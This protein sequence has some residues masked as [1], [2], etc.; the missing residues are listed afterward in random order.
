[1]CFGIGAIIQTK[2]TRAISQNL[3]HAQCD[4]TSPRSVCA[5]DPPELELGRLAIPRISQ[6][7]RR[8]QKHPAAHV[9]DN[10]EKKTGMD[11]SITD[12][13]TFR[14]ETK[15]SRQAMNG[16]LGTWSRINHAESHGL[17]AVPEKLFRSNMSKSLCREKGVFTITGRALLYILQH[18]Y[19]CDGI[20]KIGYYVENTSS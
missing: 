19:K 4:E 14:D 11:L 18:M 9:V 6:Q 12:R 3:K 10:G 2:P 16:S 17:P 20:P 8:T 1:M 13:L 5:I 7:T 15:R